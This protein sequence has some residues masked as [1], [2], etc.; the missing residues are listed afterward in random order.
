[1]CE[2]ILDLVILGTLVGAIINLY[3]VIM[4]YQRR[5]AHVFCDEELSVRHP[6]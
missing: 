6:G 4:L 3:P 1:M 2:S 5:C